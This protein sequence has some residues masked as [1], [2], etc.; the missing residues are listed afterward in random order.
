MAWSDRTVDGGAVYTAAVNPDTGKL[1]EAQ[2]V[3]V[4]DNAWISS[5]GG[6]TAMT[7]NSSSVW[8]DV[9]KLDEDGVFEDWKDGHPGENKT[10]WV[11]YRKMKN[12]LTVS[13]YHRKF[14]H[15]LALPTNLVHV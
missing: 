15:Q 9:D 2:K 10:Y 5:V 12:F 14:D 3:G 7:W 4:G 11:E 1:T 8:V 13:M 6:V